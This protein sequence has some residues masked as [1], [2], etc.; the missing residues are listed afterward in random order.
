MAVY[1]PLTTENH[2]GISEILFM[3]RLAIEGFMLFLLVLMILFSGL[4]SLKIK[5]MKTSALR[6]G[7]VRSI[8]FL[9]TM[10][11]FGTT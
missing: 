4:G 9:I 7:V 5:K 6:N 8:E 2:L 1:L 10:E 3:R 11:R